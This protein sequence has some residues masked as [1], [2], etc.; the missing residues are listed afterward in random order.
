M[1]GFFCLLGKNAHELSKSQIDH[2][3]LTLKHRGPDDYQ[4]LKGENFNTLFWR[5]SIVD[6]DLGKFQICICQ[7]KTE[8]ERHVGYRSSKEILRWK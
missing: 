2:I 3:N 1:C 6:Q 4:T 5:L 8:L 7:N